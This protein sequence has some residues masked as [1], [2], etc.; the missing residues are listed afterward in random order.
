MMIKKCIVKSEIIAIMLENIEAAHSIL[1]SD[2]KH[3]KKFL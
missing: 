3:Q 1:T 2:K